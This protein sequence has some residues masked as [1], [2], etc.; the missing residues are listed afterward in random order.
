MQ[1]PPKVLRH[2]QMLKLASESNTVYVGDAQFVN[3]VGK[4]N[5][6][7]AGNRRMTR[8]I[9]NAYSTIG[10]AWAHPPEN[11][12]IE[13]TS[14]D[15]RAVPRAFSRWWDAFYLFFRPLAQIT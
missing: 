11:P 5:G 10:A 8:S 3:T 9:R 4:S 15:C 12:V 1:T 2:E 7:C 13:H 6:D 14:K